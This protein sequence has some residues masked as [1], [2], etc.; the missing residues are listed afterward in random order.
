MR[1]MF[2]NCNRRREGKQGRRNSAVDIMAGVRL[3]HVNQLVRPLLIHRQLPG[4]YP[5][6]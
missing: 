5:G 4:S 3:V 2:E 6:A 1:L